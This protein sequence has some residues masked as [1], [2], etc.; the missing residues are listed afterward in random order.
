MTFDFINP[1]MLI[2]LAGLA[3]P[4]LAHLIS[5]KKYD[6]VHWGAMQFL[7]LGRNARRRLRL[8]ELLL[9]L[10]RMGLV[11]L[12]VVAL[13]RPWV[14][15]GWLTRYVS[16]QNRDVVFVI[17]GS[18]SMGWEGDG[19]TPHEAALQWA[20][21]FLEELQ[22]GDTVALIDA[23]DRPR[24]V[25]EF[26]TS[27]LDQVRAELDKLPPPAGTA[28]LAE[29]VAKA[30]QILT[31]T[32]NL[33]REVIV[34]SDGQALSW[35]ADDESLWSRI[36]DLRQ[37][38]AVRPRIWA[39]NVRGPTTETPENFL[40]DRLQ[41]SREL[42]VAGFPLRISTRVRRSGGEGPV[43][44]KVYLEVDGQRL[45]EKTL[46]LQLPPD[47]A[48]S[49]EFEYRFRSPGAHQVSV[50]LDRDLLPGD[51]R[52][53]A[54][55][56]VARALP[57]LLVDGDPQPDPARTETF[58]AK[59]ALTASSNDAPWVQAAV[60]AWDQ[61]R[62][63]DL[64][65]VEVALLMNVPRLTDT[66]LGALKDFVR[67]G[68]GLCI[69]LGDRIDVTRYR[70]RLLAADGG[71]LPA[72]LIGKAADTD[73][74][75]PGVYVSD[76]SLELPWLKRFRR[77]AG[78]GFTDA[79]FA[80]WWKVRPRVP[81]PRA[82]PSESGKTGQ[83]KPT[84]TAE[85]ARRG[86]RAKRPDAVP[87]A[88]NGLS[89]NRVSSSSD[90]EAARPPSGQAGPSPPL[91]EI[92]L[93]TGDPLLL[94]RR[95]GRGLVALWTSTLDAD[96]NTLPAKP[97]YVPFLHEL[98]FRL[99]SGKTQRNVM[100]GMPLIAPLPEGTELSELIFVGP[101]EMTFE[102][103]RAGDELRPLVQL[104]DTRLPGVYRLKRRADH[105]ADRRVRVAAGAA[106]ETI[107]ECFV[108][109]FDRTESDLRP[110]SDGE[111]TALCH[112]NR[113]GFVQTQDELR[114][115][116]FAEDSQTE[117]WH[118]LLWVFLVILVAEVVM[119]RRLVQTGHAVVEEQPAT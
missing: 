78:G 99:T 88:S 25:I 72:E 87:A 45:S 29:G 57:A 109:D 2:G 68:G 100:P 73:D 34:L 118:L 1:L 14:A 36:D 32:S 51:D 8:E 28:N 115:E 90:T 71:L 89:P 4:I 17:D 76:T 94:T 113:M 83:T 111:K 95:V 60:V 12:L 92:R 101:N 9:L 40:V 26:P 86:D 6:I 23:R 16:K 82:E 55:I 117:I 30:I 67:D 31:R 79:R 69:A 42:T 10:V 47:G 27:D 44:R 77:A 64:K 48:A 104:N 54:A 19:K 13:A 119:T 103:E 3:L 46:N 59:A 85:R 7:E 50:V 66:Q 24:A 22:T 43:L 11:A 20:R 33:V 38:P 39:V 18:Y 74:S 102:P 56:R 112:K 110:L 15:G 75:L 108:V 107:E 80:R 114:Q 49:V 84:G 5:K 91:V 21:D 93:D 62:S 53:D 97:D 61:F 105:S 35:R 63:D 37:Q 81:K 116:I 41:V 65:G 96:W 106:A 58:F 98:I 70:S 52:A